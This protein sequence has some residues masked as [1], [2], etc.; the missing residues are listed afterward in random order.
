MPEMLKKFISPFCRCRLKPFRPRRYRRSVVAATLLASFIV[1]LSVFIYAAWEHTQ[2]VSTE[3][4]MTNIRRVDA[5]K[6]YTKAEQ[7]VKQYRDTFGI[8][9]KWNSP[10]NNIYIEFAINKISGI[11]E[12]ENTINLGGTVQVEYDEKHINTPYGSEGVRTKL[13]KKDL[14]S[15]ANLNFARFDNMRYNY[16]SSNTYGNGSYKRILY[17]FDG[18]FPLIRDLS[19]F[20]FDN[21]KWV[22]SLRA[23]LSAVALR[24][25]VEN[26][27]FYLPTEQ[28]NAYLNKSTDCSYAKNQ[29]VCDVDY[30]VYK[31]TLDPDNY[32]DNARDNAIENYSYKE[33][34]AVKNLDYEPVIGI[35]GTLGRSVGSS[36]FR[37]IF[38]ILTLSCIL[39]FIDELN[40]S[41]FGEIKIATPPTIFL[42]LIFM[43][44]AYQSEL[45]QMTVLTYL[46]KYYIATYVLCMLTLT[47]AVLESKL[48]TTSN[49][50]N[51]TLHR[52]RY[53]LRI[54]FIFTFLGAP[55][56][57]YFL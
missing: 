26:E 9:K 57:I 1:T 29:P 49:Q 21:A 39:L 25:F 5:Q 27:L 23:P 31:A 17:S 19:K 51:R 53:Y 38:P 55:F 45:P 11:N 7:H 43:Q 16:L 56:V 36:F 24:F 44:S 6:Y 18:S 10:E 4:D 15:I 40:G 37:Y 20:P 42:T 46:D 28:V 41:K 50:K 52:I 33:A 48:P 34:L 3:I 54:L 13:A 30:V 22:L 12:V 47:R 32:K 8:N 14:L 2:V 35:S